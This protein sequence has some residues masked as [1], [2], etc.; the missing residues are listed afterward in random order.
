MIQPNRNFELGVAD[1]ELIEK[2]LTAEL[3]RLAQQKSMYTN[4]VNIDDADSKVKDI[5]E[6]M[7]NINDLLGR[8]HN[9]KIWF[10]PKNK[11]YV[12]G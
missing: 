12:G 3:C 8:I 1:V 9:Q 11:S 6:K 5:I 4:S 7:K 10:R 2:S